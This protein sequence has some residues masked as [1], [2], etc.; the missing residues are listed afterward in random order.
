LLPAEANL[1]MIW[2]LRRRY[3]DTVIGFSSHAPGIALSLIAYAFGARII[4]HHVT[5]NRASRGTDHGFSLEPKALQ[6]LVEDLEKVRV[7][8]GDGRKRFYPSERMPL[9]K[10]RRHQTAEGWK[11]DGTLSTDP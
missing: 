1:R 7:A 5:L 3:P 8:L 11:I 10:M 9:A 2:T 6:T 4:E